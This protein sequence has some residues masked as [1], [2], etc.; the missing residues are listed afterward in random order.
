[1]NIKRI[2]KP[3]LKIAFFKCVG[4]EH[5]EKSRD[6]IKRLKDEKRQH[7]E[8]MN[9]RLASSEQSFESE[10]DSEIQE[11]RRGK[12]EALQVMQVKFFS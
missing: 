11:L 7:E 5:L 8:E 1:V 12:V 2:L 4:K 3:N 10:K 6:I 9:E